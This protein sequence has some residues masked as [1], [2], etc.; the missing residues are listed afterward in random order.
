[1]TEEEN[2]GNPTALVNLLESEVENNP[3]QLMI[4]REN[5]EH[6]EAII[7]KELSGFEKQVLDLYLTG[8][9]Y[10]QIAKV[11]SR[12]EK[13]TDNAL[14]RLKAKLRKAVNK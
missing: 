14:Q 9:S 2:D 4:D 3:E 13:S 10:S 12:D 6:I 11:L 1:M 8:M 7:E 5:V